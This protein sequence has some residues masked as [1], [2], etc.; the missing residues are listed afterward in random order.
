MKSSQIFHFFTQTSRGACISARPKQVTA[1]GQ[2]CQ[3]L[4]TSDNIG[5]LPHNTFR[6]PECECPTQRAFRC[7]GILT[8]P[9]PFGFVQGR[10]EG[11]VSGHA[12][13]RAKKAE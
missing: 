11:F 8:S 2:R 4:G 9:A 5:R 3:Y 6:L 13:S 10:I 1:G 7:V 12:F